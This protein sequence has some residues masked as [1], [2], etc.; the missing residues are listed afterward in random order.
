MWAGDWDARMP[1]HGMAEEQAMLA[2]D[3]AAADTPVAG[4]R[5]IDAHS[6]I[7]TQNTDDFPLHPSCAVSDLDPASFTAEELLELTRTHGVGRTVLIGHDV[8]HGYDNSYMLDAVRRYPGRFAVCALIDDRDT[9]TPPADLMRSLL[10]EGVSG[11]RIDPFPKGLEMLDKSKRRADW[12]EGEGMASMWAC[13]SETRQALCCLIDPSDLPEVDAMCSRFPDTP[14]VIDHFARIGVSGEVDEADLDSLCDLARHPNVAVK[15]S[16]FYAL[17]QKCPPYH[18]LVPMITRLHAA[19]GARRL[20]WASD[21]PYQ[22]AEEATVKHTY[23]DS[24]AL[25]QQPDGPLSF[26]TADE[27]EWILWKAAEQTFFS[28]LPSEHADGS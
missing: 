8:F 15:L 13:A 5:I 10:L 25:I 11:F 6:H 12:L 22:L 1:G 17:G 14:V 26:L 20:M 2:A 27:R 3:L 9:T 28:V 4:G 23:A 19:F 21:C 18:D 16:A 7:W 24:L